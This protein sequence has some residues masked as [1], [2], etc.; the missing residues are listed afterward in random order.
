MK[1]KYKKKS[2]NFK[3]IAR[4]RIQILFKEADLMFKE[5]SSLSDRYVELARKIAMKYK[6]RIPKEQKKRFCKH[7]YK[8]LV[9]GV[10]CRIRNN[11]S[12]IVYYCQNCKNYMRYPLK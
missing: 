5:D 9:P 1:Q 10:N 6:I 7:C 8:F 12:K 11:N 4:E 2:E 3:E